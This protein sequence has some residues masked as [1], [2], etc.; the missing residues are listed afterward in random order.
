MEKIK[1]TSRADET[2]DHSARKTVWSPPRQLDAPDPPE[3]FKYRWLRESIQG[4]ADDKNI[5]S[6]LREGYELVRQDELS[7]SEKLKYPAIAAGKYSGVVGVGGLLLAKIPLELANQRNEYYA[8]L[9]KSQEESVENDVFKDEHPS[10]P[11]TNNRSSKVTFGGGRG[12][13][14]QR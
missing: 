3:G 13:G 5:V 8:N 10:M 1:K 11:I 2:R 12:S 14:G 6:R 4:Q 7:D 9:H